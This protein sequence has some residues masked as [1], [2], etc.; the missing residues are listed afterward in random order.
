MKDAQMYM[1]AIGIAVVANFVFGFIWYTSLFGKSYGREW[2]SISYKKQVTLR[3][4]KVII[5]SVLGNFLMAQVYS[6]NSKAYCFVPVD[7]GTVFREHKS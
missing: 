6:Q 5:T 3:I 7:A 4:R 1:M 2:A